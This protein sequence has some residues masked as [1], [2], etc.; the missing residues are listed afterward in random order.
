MAEPDAGPEAETDTSAPIAAEADGAEPPTPPPI[1]ADLPGVAATIFDLPRGEAKIADV[2]FPRRAYQFMPLADYLRQRFNNERIGAA[3]RAAIADRLRGQASPGRGRIFITAA[4]P[5]LALVAAEQLFGDRPARVL[6]ASEPHMDSAGF[7]VPQFNLRAMLTQAA[8]DILPDEVVLLESWGLSHA[9]IERQLKEAPECTLVLPLDQHTDL[10]CPNLEGDGP[11]LIADIAAQMFGQEKWAGGKDWL[12]A[13]IFDAAQ[14]RARRVQ[15]VNMLNRPNPRELRAF[16]MQQGEATEAGRLNYDEFREDEPRFRSALFVGAHFPGIDAANFVRLATPLARLVPVKNEKKS[17]GDPLH[18]PDDEIARMAGVQFLDDCTSIL[19]APAGADEAARTLPADV[20]TASARRWFLGRRLL[21]DT[22]IDDL[23][24]HLVHGNADQDIANAL[25]MLEIDALAS[26]QEASSRRAAERLARLLFGWLAL[27]EQPKG[28]DLPA[29]AIAAAL[30]DSVAR[31]PAVLAQ[32]GLRL[33]YLDLGEVV[34][35]LTAT[36]AAEPQNSSLLADACARLFWLFFFDADAAAARP[37]LADFTALTSLDASLGGHAWSLVR[38]LDRMSREGDLLGVSGG[39]RLL[40]DIAARFDDVFSS[41]IRGEAIL[42]QALCFGLLRPLR[43]GTWSGVGE[44]PTGTDAAALIELGWQVGNGL[45]S[46]V[47]AS[48]DV[49]TSIADASDVDWYRLFAGFI[50]VSTMIEVAT[51]SSGLDG[52]EKD[53]L[54]GWVSHL[55]GAGGM[56]Y[57]DQALWRYERGA[58]RHDGL[59]AFEQA[60]ALLYTGIPVAFAMLACRIEADGAEAAKFAVSDDLR[61]WLLEP[62]GTGAQAGKTRAGLLYEGVM[63][64][65][66]FGDNWAEVRRRSGVP[67]SAKARSLWEERRAALRAFAKVLP[68]RTAN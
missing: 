18:A 50:A 59:A 52:V 4:H 54:D 29:A 24:L 3:L 55:V 16:L 25:A 45:I 47:S 67:Q 64:L 68:R 62:A 40:A 36:V 15:I 48:E 56:A 30:R 32:L 12:A 13:R 43:G 14:D 20:V 9:K 60:T 22:F 27:A 41:P 23:A 57:H 51:G 26:G 53:V 42:S 21:R 6:T 7:P 66:R 63:A 35:H 19:C 17:R 38:T 31:A 2:G 10:D 46:R 58:I 44:L 37:S 5:L 1:V 28:V 65:G 34:R 33:P 11:Q 61:V 8:G 49:D 39:Q